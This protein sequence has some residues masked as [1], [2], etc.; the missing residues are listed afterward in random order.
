[1]DAAH[2]GITIK[3]EVLL[4]AGT[5]ASITLRDVTIGLENRVSAPGEGE[6]L[7]QRIN[8]TAAIC[9]SAEMMGMIHA[10]YGQTIAY[11]Q[12][13][14]QF[15]KRIEVI[16]PCSTVLPSSL[17]NRAMQKCRY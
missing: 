9:L 2:E 13:R 6:K 12:E 4:D 7:I 3:T 16:K 17:R 14:Q 11:L 1:M 15:G 10:A 8:N 5:Y